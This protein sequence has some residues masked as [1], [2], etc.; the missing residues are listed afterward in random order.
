MVVQ[1]SMIYGAASKPGVSCGLQPWGNTVGRSLVSRSAVMIH[2]SFAINVIYS[3]WHFHLEFMFHHSIEVT[4]SFVPYIVFWSRLQFQVNSCCFVNNLK[5]NVFDTFPFPLLNPTLFALCKSRGE[6][7]LRG[8]D[9]N[10]P[11]V[12]KYL[13]GDHVIIMHNHHVSTHECISCL[14]YSM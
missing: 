7:S 5:V 13:K 12:I 14:I 11:D 9:C 10:I 1:W 2:Y 8:K 4:K 3:S 6:I